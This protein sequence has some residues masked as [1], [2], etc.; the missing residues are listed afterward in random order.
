MAWIEPKTNW[1][2]DDPIT[3]KDLNRIEG[4][5]KSLKSGVDETENNLSNHIGKKATDTELGHLR[6]TDIPVPSK[7]SIG[8]GNVDNVKQMPQ[9]GGQFTGI[10]KAHSNTS[11]TTAQIRNIIL[12]PND[13][14][15]NA[16]QN[17]E[18]WIKY[19]E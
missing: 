11:Y 4:N 5:T 9:S 6:L 19:R 10:V 13:A 16:M 15:V 17:G 1:T 2:P 8:L 7:E 18:I 14:N 12:S 3:E